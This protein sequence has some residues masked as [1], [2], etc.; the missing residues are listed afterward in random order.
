[1]A[2]KT[3]DFGECFGKAWEIY[4]QNLMLLVGA[5][6]VVYLI[7]SFSLGIVAG[8]LSAGLLGL[9]LKLIDGRSD[10]EFGDIFGRFDVF[11]P[12]FLLGLAWGAAFYVVYLV[13]SFIPLI[14]QLA[15][16]LL[17]FGYTIF[18]MFAI[19]QVAEK[20]MGFGDASKSAFEMLKAD[21]WP[22]IGYSAVASIIS[23]VGIFACGIGVFF[24]LPIAIVMLV[25]AY[26]S[27]CE[28]DGVIDVTAETAEIVDAPIPAPP[29]APADEPIDTPEPT[30]EEEPPPAAQ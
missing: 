29:P 1:M 17:S 25:V 7:S 12:T 20:G 21:F 16:I 5:S 13:L 14:G 19:M 30:D 11:L 6:A 9:T 28:E 3:F 4:K 24:T 8:P 18:L 22:L 10:G 27:C 23:G 26:R 15:G 2:G